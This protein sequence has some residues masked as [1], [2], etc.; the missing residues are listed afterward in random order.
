MVS[1]DDTLCMLVNLYVSARNI[2]DRDVFTKSDPKCILYEKTA[3]GSWHKLG[4]T[5]E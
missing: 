3:D 4:K 1:A 2:F 5:E